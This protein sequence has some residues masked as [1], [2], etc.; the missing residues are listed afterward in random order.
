MKNF[1]IATSFVKKTIIE[2]AWNITLR[3]SVKKAITELSKNDQSQG[4]VT[5]L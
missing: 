4:I 1:D 3:T 2:N 5:T